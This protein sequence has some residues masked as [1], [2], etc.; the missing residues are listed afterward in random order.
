M[1]TKEYSGKASDKNPISVLSYKWK[2][3]WITQSFNSQ[4][5]QLSA[6]SLNAT[7]R[8]NRHNIF[9]P[10]VLQASYFLA[11]F[12]LGPLAATCV[13]SPLTQLTKLRSNCTISKE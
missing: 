12:L 6:Q 3:L 13:N 7:H 1:N 9:L 2:Y 8:L 11:R 5:I 10:L 4:A